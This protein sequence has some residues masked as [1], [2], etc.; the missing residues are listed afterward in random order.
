M[1]SKLKRLVASLLAVCMIASMMPPVMAADDPASASSV[2]STSVVLDGTEKQPESEA[3][4]A[5]ASSEAESEASSAPASSE[6]ESEASSAP[7]SSEAESEASSAPASSEAESEASSAPASSEAESEASSAPASSEAES[8]ASSAP[9]SSEAESEASSAPAS[10]EAESKASSAAVPEA[11]ITGTTEGQP[12]VN[13]TVDGGNGKYFRIPSL[14]TLDNGWLVA[15]ADMRWQTTADSPQ[16]LDTIVSLSKDGGKTWSYEIVNYFDDRSNSTTGQDSASFIDPSMVQGPDGKLYMVVDACPSYAGLMWGNRMGWESSGFDD[17]GRMLVAKAQA[18]GDA[19]TQKSE[20]QYRVDLNAQPSEVTVAGET[21]RLYPITTADGQMTGQWVDAWLD[22]YAWDGTSALVEKVMAKQLDSDKMVQDNLFYRSSEWKAYPVFYIMLRSAEVTESGL[23][24]GEPKFLNIKYSENEAFTGVCPGRGL[25]TQVNG[26]DRILFPLYDNATGTEYASVIYSDDGGATWHRGERVDDL[27]SGSKTSESQAVN[28][29]DGGIRLFCRNLGGWI[30]Y[31]DSYDG[32]QTWSAARADSQLNYVSNCMVS[33]INAEG[34]LQSPEGKVYGNLV[35][36]SYPKGS[37]R[38]NGVIRVGSMHPNTGTIEWLDAGE[39]RYPGVYQY[40]CLTQKSGDALGLLTEDGTGVISYK[41]LTMTS[42]LGEGWTYLETYAGQT[43]DGLS[44]VTQDQP[45][46]PDQTGGSRRFRIPAMVTLDNGW[47]LTAADARWGS[48]MDAANNLDGLVSLSKDGGKTWEWEMVNHFADYPDQTPGAYRPSASFIDPALTQ[49]EDGT[50]Y[51]VV[52]AC[53]AYSG[54][55]NG[56][57][58]GT[59]STG[60]N[61]DGNVVIA[62]GEPNSGIASLNAADYTYY[63]DAKAGKSIT[64]DGQAVTVYPIKEEAGTETGGWVDADYDL[65]ETSGGAIVPSLCRQ[66]LSGKTVQNN[67]FYEQSPW[68]I[69]P[70]FHIWLR[71][72]TVT[73]TGIEWSAPQ[74]L[75]IKQQGE[76]F[77]GVC[78]G[79][80]LTVRLENGAERVMFQV[81]DNATGQERA[82]TIYTD[83]GGATWHRGQHVTNNVGKTSESQTVL[84]PDGGIRIY[85]RNNIGYISYADSYDGGITWSESHRDDQLDY[86]GN[87]MVSFINVEGSLVGPDGTVYPNLIAA[88]YPKGSGRNNGVIRVGS[89]GEN[90]QVTWLNEADVK[91]PGSYLYSCLTQLENGTL[92]LLYEKEDTSYGAGYIL[93]DAF[94]M[95]SLLGEGWNYLIDTPE[96]APKMELSVSGSELYAGEQAVVKAVVSGVEENVTVAWSLA[97]DDGAEVAKLDRTASASG[98]QVV[99]TALAAGKATLTAKAEVQVGSETMELVRS[100]RIYVSDASVITLPDEYDKNSVSGGETSYLRENGE[101]A[102]G[103]YAFVDEVVSPHRILYYQSG[104]ATTDQ[105]TATVNGDTLTLDSGYAASRQTWKVTKEAQG[106]TL[107]S[108]DEP[109]KYLNVTGVTSSQLPVS[110][111]KAYFNIEPAGNGRLYLS[112]QVNGETLYVYVQGKFGAS[113]TKADSM[114]AFAETVLYNVDA[115]GLKALLADAAALDESLYTPETWSK[116]V[117]ALEA[118]QATA[119][120]AEGAFAGNDQ[121]Q[122]AFAA[123]QQNTQALYKAVL[124]L[125]KRADVEYTV[126]YK[127]TGEYFAYDSF[128]VQTYT[129][130]EAIN[131]PKAPAHEGYSFSGW[132]GLPETMPEQDLVVTGSYTKNAAPDPTPTPEPNP[133][134]TPAPSGDD[135][136]REWTDSSTPTPT[137]VPTTAPSTAVIRGNGGRTQTGEKDKAGEKDESTPESSP[138][139]VEPTPATES[140]APAASEAPESEADSAASSAAEPAQSGSVMPAVIGIAVAAVVAACVVVFVVKRR[141]QQ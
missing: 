96:S 60:F 87:C 86:V 85:S 50:I 82:S 57:Q 5:P 73:E 20:Y 31:A 100:C 21:L 66:A 68:K 107:E 16:N 34:Y 47:I 44:G 135:G 112:T 11:P 104:K 4:S 30:T 43:E 23:A 128:A 109:G 132:Q 136:D 49:G 103:V 22:L 46:I 98:Q 7:A 97:G 114:A 101:L 71:T 17:Q 8:E 19:P 62:K 58:A 27:T 53:P 6:A 130:G 32:G 56:G 39:V 67:V 40:S 83:D 84:L 14:V 90:N 127:I 139:P 133:T 15:A 122:N 74:I 3:S 77:V 51:M 141:K 81:Y 59:Q 63:V 94:A 9:A 76:G 13:D 69:Y 18:N 131:A 123:V 115:A 79:R 126:T 110:T 65:Y 28:L 12:F 108:C 88:S 61:E 48:T 72:G 52:D 99:L 138:T 118:A 129:M 55:Q 35:V 45:Y 54:L 124:D 36:A 137:P 134:P 64:V 92:G 120:S 125:E 117:K 95:T 75:N 93:Y 25:V 121:A 116:L 37:G 89:I 78:P 26:K 140:E 91:Y 106:Y 33:F 119:D 29:P 42:V 10:S 1:K 24:W 2:P 102:D 113:K 38:N 111:N 70:T 41:D 105:V 80:G